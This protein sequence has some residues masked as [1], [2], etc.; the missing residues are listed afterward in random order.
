LLPAAIL[1]GQLH[2][3]FEMNGKISSQ[4]FLMKATGARAPLR[5]WL[6]INRGG[7]GDVRRLTG[8]PVKALKIFNLTKYAGRTPEIF[9][10]TGTPI[11]GISGG[12]NVADAVKG[13][14]N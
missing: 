3:Y 11:P 12:D 6:G 8:Y 1:P 14:G 5:L 2:Q 10:G 4:H 7:H 9:S 13:K